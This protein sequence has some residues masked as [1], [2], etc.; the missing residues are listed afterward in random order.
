MFCP[1]IILSI[2]ILIL[3][4][5]RATVNSKMTIESNSRSKRF[6]YYNSENRLS[7]PPGTSLYLTPT[8]QLPSGRNLP[9]GYGSHMTVSLPFSINF[10]DLGMTSEENP[11]GL[12]PEF[13]KIR[14]KR[15]A[16]SPL[17]GVNWAGGDREVM[18]QVVE[19]YLGLVGLPG[20]ACLLRAI[21]EMFET[22]LPN[23]GF[24]GDVIEL[25]F[26]VSKSPH[27][28]KR[29]ADYL[30]AETLGKQHK[31]CSK[32]YSGCEHSLFANNGQ[33]KWK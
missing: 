4:I 23:H 14:E 33:S 28:E 18:F 24:F 13:G 31:S 25:F 1:K 29:M 22:P 16:W 9:I 19:D 32:F 2:M 6:I 27:A 5:A 21:C 7:L 26:S 15:E 20:K 11:W 3:G 17:P 10:D 30:E 8:L 12:W